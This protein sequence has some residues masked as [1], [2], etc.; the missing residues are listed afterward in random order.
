MA[1][2]AVVAVAVVELVVVAVPKG[3]VVAASAVAL[4]QF[5]QM[6]FLGVTLELVTTAAFLTP[7]VSVAVAVVWKESP[8]VPASWPSC[9]SVSELTHLEIVVVAALACSRK[10][11]RQ[12]CQAITLTASA[13]VRHAGGRSGPW[14]SATWGRCISRT[15]L[16]GQFVKIQLFTLTELALCFVTF[17]GL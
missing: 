13:V 8:A 15:L 17:G 14:A 16:H 10:W 3:V 5:E 7:A 4:T 11:G 6:A 1:E 12:H 9:L 2:E